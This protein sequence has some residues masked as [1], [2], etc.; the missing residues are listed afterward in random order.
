MGVKKKKPKILSGRVWIL[1]FC[2]IATIGLGGI[3]WRVK[4]INERQKI[5]SDNKWQNFTDSNRGFSL[6]Y[7][8]DWEVIDF[9]TRLL[10]QPKNALERE[11]IGVDIQNWEE[12]DIEK[13]ADTIQGYEMGGNLREKITIAGKNGIHLRNDKHWE[14]IKVLEAKKDWRQLEGYFN[15]IEAVIIPQN[16]QLIVFRYL[17]NTTRYDQY[18]TWMYPGFLDSLKFY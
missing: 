15:P 2:F 13:A 3:Y 18:F 4:N 9:G 11:R 16:N 14:Q 5:Y 8:P 10:F 17:K 1:L 7:P 6:E 12:P